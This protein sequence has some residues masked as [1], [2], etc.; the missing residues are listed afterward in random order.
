MSDQEKN[1]W[2]LADTLFKAGRY[3]EAV[4]QYTSLASKS[5][6]PYVDGA[7]YHIMQSWQKMLINAYQKDNVRAP[8]ALRERVVVAE[9][10]NEREVFALVD[11]HQAFISAADDIRSDTFEDIPENAAYIK[12]LED[13]RVALH[14]TPAQ[15]LFEYGRFEEARPRLEEVIELFPTTNEA[16]FSAN[17]L[18]NSFLEEG[19]LDNVRDLLVRF[20]EE[21]LGSDPEAITQQQRTFREQLEQTVYKLA[22]RL[23]AEGKVLPAANAYLSFT[24]EFPD[25]EYVDEALYT[26]AVYF[27]NAGR[28]TRAN[29]LYEDFINRYPDHP[30]AEGLTF[31]I[32]KNSADVLDFEKALEYYGRILRYFGDGEYADGALI[33]SALLKVGLGDSS[34]A[35]KALEDYVE[36]YPE[37]E[38]LEDYLWLA[39]QQWELAGDNKALAF[40]QRYLG[41]RSGIHP[42]HTLEALNWIAEYYT[43]SGNRRAESARQELVETCNTFLAEGKEPGRRGRNLAATVVLDELMEKLEEFR[44][45]D[46]PDAS[47]ISF[48]QAFNELTVTKREEL[49]AIATQADFIFNNYADPITT[50]GA[51]YAVGWLSWPSLSSTTTR[52]CPRC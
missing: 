12:A 14:Y 38:N 27:N 36:R 23:K 7:R 46:Y 49:D 32:A 43:K 10:G 25:S 40:Y 33:N 31:D 13:D 8:E 41:A 16:A 44:S 48:V 34:G 11:A 4:E 9:N 19:D 5:G 51:F 26:A 3:E 35:A 6:H 24:E 1:Q 21:R 52:R 18:V 15:I 39:A 45:I 17:L 42:G 50:M 47:K 22:G 30:D 2:Y 28:V 29:D 20:S 37:D